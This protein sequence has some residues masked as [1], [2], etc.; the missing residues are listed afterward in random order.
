MKRTYMTPVAVEE[1]FVANHYIAACDWHI[2][3]TSGNNRMQCANP[4]HAHFKN[5]EY[6]TS[7]WV[8]A[9]NSTCQIMV[10]QDGIG[11][12]EILNNNNFRPAEG[13]T[14][15]GATGITYTCT[16]TYWRGKTRYYVPSFVS[17]PS[18]QG[19]SASNP[20][21]GTYVNTGDYNEIMEKVQS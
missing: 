15:Y 1:A 10:T 12:T 17:G 7:V 5:G 6:F 20:C 3:S 8:E 18:N 9:T 14:V 2:T 4:S 19:S 13:A 21:Y 16:K 11:R